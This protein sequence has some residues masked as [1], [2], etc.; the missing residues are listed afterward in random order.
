MTVEVFEHDGVGLAV[1]DA[2]GRGV[3]FVFQHGLGGSAAQTAEVMPDVPGIRALTLE[4]RGHGASDAGSLQDLSIATFA[5][6]VAALIAARRL[7]PAIIGGISMGAAIAARLSVTQPGLVRALV[8]ARPAWVNQAAPANMAR[9]GEVGALL[10]AHPANTAREM[11]SA[12][13]TAR[14]LTELAPDNLTSL[15]G[16]FDRA[17]QATTAS[18]LA[19]IAFDGPGITAA[20]LSAIACPVLIIGHGDDLAHP[21][22]MCQELAA[23]IPQARLVEVTSKVKSKSAYVSDI[24]AALAAFL[25]EF[26]DG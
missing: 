1:H 26:A 25:K 20:D 4:C 17:P 14:R 16:F 12:S 21:W 2:G 18:L 22:A 15:L 10:A 5:D 6:D 11:F 7:A 23:L 24:K 19:R 8:L 13:A 3:P 9:Y